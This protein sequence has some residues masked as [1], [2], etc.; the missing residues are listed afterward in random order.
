MKK[1]FAPKTTPV[2]DQD[3]LP[4]ALKLIAKA[5]KRIDLMSFSFA[6]G[7]AAGKINYSAAPYKLAEAIANLKK[8]RPEVQVRFFVEGLRETIDRN[9]IT[10]EFL[11]ER[12]VEVRYGSTHAKGF[13]VDDRYVLF[14]S[15]NL[16]NQSI[17]KNHEANLLI[18]DKR[19]AAQFTRYFE[20]HWKGGGHGEIDLEEPFL[21]DGAFEEATIELC[22]TAKRTLDFSIYFFNHRGIEKAIV[23]AHQRG[24]KVKG[25]IHQHKSFAYPYV[26]RNRATVKRMRSEGIEDLHLSIPT[27]FSHSKYIVMD[28]KEIL[29]GTGN[30]LLEDVHIHPQLYVHLKDAAV[31]RALIKHLNMQIKKAKTE[32]VESFRLSTSFSYA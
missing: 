27:T 6:I 7:S 28:R 29:L 4:T 30:W 14:G 32:G 24:V 20:H 21:A 13:C 12:G 26:A 2:F 17:M 15:T 5:K 22:R 9:R 16:T 19:A 8:K 11:E 10:A 31:S 3:Y 1:P 25:F 18:D 23:E